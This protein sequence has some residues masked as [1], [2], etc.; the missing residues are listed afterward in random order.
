MMSALASST[1]LPSRNARVHDLTGASVSLCSLDDLRLEGGP[2][3][4]V[5]QHL[6]RRDDG[7]DRQAVFPCEIVVALVVR[8]AAEDGAGAVAHEDE[9]G[10]VD[11]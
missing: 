6:V 10:D 4:G 5:V 11:G 7:D 3:V 1:A 2:L 8:G 9:I